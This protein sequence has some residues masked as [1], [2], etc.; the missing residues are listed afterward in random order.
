[1]PI[2]RG[3][4]GGVL[5]DALVRYE[6]GAASIELN[7]RMQAAS[8]ERGKLRHTFCMRRKDVAEL[9][10]HRHRVALSA[11]NL[12]F[13]FVKGALGFGNSLPQGQRDLHRCH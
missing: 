5:G 12:R 1:M 13:R 9:A 4:V 2:G 3:N 10:G 11:A 7:A 8:G 6:A